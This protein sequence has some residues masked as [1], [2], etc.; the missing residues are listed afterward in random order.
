[1]KKVI[2]VVLACFFVTV[3]LTCCGA[4]PAADGYKKD[5]DRFVVAIAEGGNTVYVDTETGVMY[6]FRK[7]GYEGGMTVM[8][9]ADG[10]PL[11]WEGD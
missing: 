3:M 10:K 1:M 8:V 9:D 5:T 11:I 7:E 2:F 4:T 6:L